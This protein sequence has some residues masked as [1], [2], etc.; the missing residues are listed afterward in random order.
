MECVEGDTLQY[1][2][3]CTPIIPCIITLEYFPVCGVNGKTYSNKSSL[4]CD[5]M[6][7]DYEG[8]CNQTL[9]P[10]DLG[11]PNLAACSCL[12]EY[13]PV[14]GVNNKTYNSACLAGCENVDVAY[15]GVCRNTRTNSI[16]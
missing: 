8:S 14:C 6:S 7:L 12:F 4:K 16:A 3:E 2:G 1:Q 9:I 13:N 10:D 11:P 5:R 15:K